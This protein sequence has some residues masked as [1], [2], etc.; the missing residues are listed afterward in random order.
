MVTN[1]IIN[2][3]PLREKLTAYAKKAGKTATRPIL[4]LFFVLK[5][6]D[7]PKS[8]KLLIVSA[9]SY[10]VLP[11]DLISAKRLPVIG[12]IDEIVSITYAYKK[13]RK[14][15]TPEIERKVESL[16]MDW[17]PEVEYEII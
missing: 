10:L 9:L 13:V 17:F 5:S 4:L 15:I 16:L 3:S 7:T 6:P 1:Q 2:Y 11:I 12:W 8:D 14:H